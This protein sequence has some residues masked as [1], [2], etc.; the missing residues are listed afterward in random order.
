MV[1]EMGSK[2]MLAEACIMLTES[3]AGHPL[4]KGR[5]EA[6]VDPGAFPQPFL[7]SCI[8]WLDLE[9]VTA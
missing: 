4:L 6:Q 5:E 2:A 3:L 1:P 7:M 9:S 8:M